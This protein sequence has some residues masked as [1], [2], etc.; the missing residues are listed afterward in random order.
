MATT[1]AFGKIAGSAIKK[2]AF[3]F[4]DGENVFRIVGGIL[5][6]YAYWLK[7]ANN[8][9]IPMECISFDR[10][11]ERFTN[12]ETDWVQRMHP[13]LKCSWSYLVNCIDPAD[14]KVKTLNLK[15]KMFAQIME[16]A[17]SLGDPTDPVTGWDVVV[18]RSKNGPLAF[19]VDYSVMVLKLKPRA[20]TEAELAAVA[21]SETIDAKFPRP[22]AEDQ[23]AFLEKLA[24]GDTDEPETDSST[25]EAVSDLG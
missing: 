7:G 6:R 23:K 2:E 17:E 4:K 11:Q 19:N 18:K 25:S 16:A 13:E 12:K 22:T 1:K 15:K 9:D 20:L 10:D 5:P 21:A 24:A 3:V 8:K 14:G